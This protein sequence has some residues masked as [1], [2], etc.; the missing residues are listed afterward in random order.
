MKT[1]AFTSSGAALALAVL[2]S[3][4]GG[5]VSTPQAETATAELTAT[6]TATPTPT[7]TPAPTGPPA[8]SG[9]YTSALQL[10]AAV[11]AAGLPCSGWAE[12]SLEYAL[13]AGNCSEGSDI[14]A[15]Y[16]PAGLEEQLAAWTAFGTLVEMKVLVGQNW[17]VN[18]ELA[19]QLQEELGGQ[20]FTTSG[21]AK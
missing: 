20:I 1:R 16:S 18:S 11:E 9:S 12:Q 6:A 19:E 3:G 10:K 2:L 14:L 15:V 8:H 4:C 7:P 5:S 21:P 13:S 17:T